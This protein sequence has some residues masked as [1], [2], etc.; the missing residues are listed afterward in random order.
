MK[1]AIVSGL[2]S[3][4]M[5]PVLYSH[6]SQMPRSSLALLPHRALRPLRGPC[7]HCSASS[8]LSSVAYHDDCVYLTGVP[9]LPPGLGGYHQLP[10]KPEAL[11]PTSTCPCWWCG[12]PGP[13]EYLKLHPL[14]HNRC[15]K[16][17]KYGLN[18]RTDQNSRNRPNQKRD[19]Q[20]ISFVQFKTL[21]IRMFT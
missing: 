2:N 8:S 17:K 9:E 7:H 19:G 14:Q 11:L 15:A 21:V 20:P 18:E 16:T 4:W 5:E 1:V 13:G 12:L 3:A 10:D 6:G